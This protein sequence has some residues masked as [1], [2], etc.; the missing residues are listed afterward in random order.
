MKMSDS[1]PRSTNSNPLFKRPFF[2]KFCSVTKNIIVI[3][4]ILY[5][6]THNIY[7]IWYIYT[8]DI[9]T[10]YVHTTIILYNIITL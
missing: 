9:Y 5:I 10:I 2:K 8:L 1:R 7:Y 6:D 4:K 3:T